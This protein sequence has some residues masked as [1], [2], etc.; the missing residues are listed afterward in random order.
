MRYLFIALL[1]FST[2]HAKQ[3]VVKQIHTTSKKIKTYDQKSSNLHKKMARTAKTIKKTEKELALQKKKIEKL[4]LQ[5]KASQEQYQSNQKELIDLQSKQKN[6][7]GEQAVVEQ[8]LIDSIARNISINALEK[9]RFNLTTEAIMTEEILHALNMQTQRKISKLQQAHSDN[10]K[11]INRYQE[12]TLALQKSIKKIDR[13]KKQLVELSKKKRA[14]LASLKK[15]KAYYKRSIKNL[16][17]QKKSLSSTLARL[18]IIKS[19][20]ERKAKSTRKSRTKGKATAKVTNKGSSYQR[21][22]TKKYRGKKTIAPLARY[23]L[24]K[25]FGPYTDPIYKIKIY[26]ESVSLQPTQQSAKVRTV[27]NGKI[28]LAKKTQLLDN[29]VIIKH[30]NGL[31]TIYAHLD[32]IAPN[33][34]K[35]KRVKKGATIGRVDNELT[36]E[37]T[38]D[39][40]HI[41]PMALIK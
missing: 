13:Q 21:V 18:N 19:E 28:I 22:K 15:D 3:D 4:T 36:F 23:R 41:D 6:L 10:S 17:A 1:L 26:N 11:N 9:E 8:E 33:I 32:Q 35:G 27:L 14:S 30:S 38:Q 29:V 25:K 40:Y 20:E 34:R 16:M 37:V 12:R 5:L 31:H 39:S 2:L 24:I 7:Q